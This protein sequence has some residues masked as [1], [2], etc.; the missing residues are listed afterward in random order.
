MARERRRAPGRRPHDER[1][2]A[3]R[4]LTAPSR[5]LASVLF[6]ERHNRRAA[7]AK[8][9]L[10]GGA[11]AVDLPGLRGA[12]KLMDELVALGEACRSE[13]MAS[14]ELAAG[15]VGDETPP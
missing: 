5:V 6:V 7:E 1:N 13:R 15:P 4:H 14:R 8:I 2:L 10:K 11:R 9:V 12:A 3:R